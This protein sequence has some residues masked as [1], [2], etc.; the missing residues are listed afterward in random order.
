[1]RYTRDGGREGR[2]AAAD[3]MLQVG[4]KTGGSDLEERRRIAPDYSC[5]GDYPQKMQSITAL[6]AL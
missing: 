5:V 1:M 3:G 6:E 2:E 4:N